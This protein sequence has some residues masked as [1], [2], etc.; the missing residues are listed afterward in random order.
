MALLVLHGS[1]LSAQNKTLPLG[2]VWQKVLQHHPSL[3][4][5]KETI[6]QQELRRLLVAK[7]FLPELQVQAQQNYG[8]FLN[9]PASSFPL[10]GSYNIAGTGNSIEAANGG[11]GFG[12]SALLQW[13]F[14]QF[15]RK[16]KKMDAADAALRLSVEDLGREELR[17]LSAASRL[18]FS[19]LKSEALLQVA[20][21]D[22][23]RLG[24]LLDL[25]KAQAEAGL[26]PGAD[27]LLIKAAM[28]QAGARQHEHRASLKGAQLTLAALMGEDLA[29]MR[30][31]TSLFHRFSGTSLGPGDEMDKHPYLQWLAAR[32]EL[33]EAERRVVKKEV[34]PSVS[35]LAGIGA[36]GSSVT[37]DGIASKGILGSWSN[38]HGNY[39]VGVGV[40]WNLS[41]LLQN[42]TRRA[43]ADREIL[44]AK[45][46]RKA[47]KIQLEG[48]Y[49]AAL[50]GWQEQLSK[51]TAARASLESS[52]EAYALYDVRYQS[53]LISLVELLQLQANL[54]EA[55][56]AYI[57]A[58]AGYWNELL[59]QAEVLG[60]P[61]LLLTAIQP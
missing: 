12:T 4:S 30:L 61:V 23:R 14:L 5:K 15:G 6:Q 43:I 45:A 49:G 41:S 29:G 46:D 60:N 31:D 3:S 1:T 44:A 57:S 58:L 18:Y 54:Q 13:N 59:N 55:E 19:A 48:M 7:Q 56:R 33:A 2:E 36:R 32:E 9:M 53:G 22:A 10:P 34:Y 39:L 20:M 50:A 24:D 21:T 11:S 37:A 52:R 16:Q 8:S 17:L 51:L 38:M 27:T 25:L 28:L 26:R 35:L 42:K 47:A 40:T